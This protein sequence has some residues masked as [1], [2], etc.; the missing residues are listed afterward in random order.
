[1][2]LISQRQ[3]HT[4]I[5]RLY[6]A[7]SGSGGT[8]GS[9]I[10]KST[11]TYIPL[12]MKEE[13]ISQHDEDPSRWN[14]IALSAS[15]GANHAN[16]AT[17]LGLAYWRGSREK[18]LKSLDA[19]QRER[20]EELRQKNVSAW[21]K[22]TEVGAGSGIRGGYKHAKP[23]TILEE[24]EK[25]EVEEEEQ[26]IEVKEEVE[27]LPPSAWTQWLEKESN[28]SPRLKDVLHLHLWRL[29]QRKEVTEMLYV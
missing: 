10:S 15:F 9:S 13:I 16:V 12:E 7:T 3:A 27:V 28:Y 29:E 8:S 2:K 21:S 20:L 24:D 5:R 19:K 26:E 6:S 1:M 23:S 14:A 11:P 4:T 25:K 22:L 18:Y 17:L